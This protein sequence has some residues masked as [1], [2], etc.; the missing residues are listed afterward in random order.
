M[1]N[2]ITKQHTGKINLAGK[3]LLNEFPHNTELFNNLVEVVNTG[4]EYYTTHYYNVHGSNR[5]FNVKCAKFDDGVIVSHEDV[6]SLILTKQQLKDN[7][8]LLHSIMDISGSGINYA[9]ALRNK[10]NA[11]IDFLYV[12]CNKAFTNIIG[13]DLI[14]KRYSEFPHARQIGL[15]DKMKKVVEKG[16][17]L[18]E[19]VFFV[20]DELNKWFHL[21]SI[22]QQDG[23]ITFFE[24]IAERKP[25]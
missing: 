1:V 16:I 23:V 5:W 8:D 21:K 15:M 25:S 22:K 19:D 7:E 2:K 10:K 12:L 20:Q 17:R 13:Q 18:E 9:I 6:S 14:G 11:I 3:T 4:E 24:E